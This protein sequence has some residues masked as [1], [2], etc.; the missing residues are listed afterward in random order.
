MWTKRLFL[1]LSCMLT[2]LLAATISAQEITLQVWD[3]FD[4]A[5]SKDAVER[6]KLFQR[7]EEENPGIKIQHNILTYSDLHEKLVV[8]GMAGSGPDIVHMLGE[9]VPEFVLLGIIEDVTDR[10][11][12]WDEK[13]FFP[14]STWKVA[15]YKERIY[16]VPSIASPRVLLYREDYLRRSGF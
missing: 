12:M 3:V 4:P 11:N 2:V 10:V 15:T 16:G 1:V 7:F 5:T 13:Q 14:D 8:A 6:E 9:W